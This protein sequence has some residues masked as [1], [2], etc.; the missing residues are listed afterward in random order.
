MEDVEEVKEGEEVEDRESAAAESR[1]A[2]NV[3]SFGIAA[4]S[5][6]TDILC[7]SRLNR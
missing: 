4:T 6:L 7:G 5:Y 3:A 1:L 2:R